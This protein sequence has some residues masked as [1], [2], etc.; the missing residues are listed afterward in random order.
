MGFDPAG[1]GSDEAVIAYRYGGWYGEMIAAKGADTADGSSMAALLMK[2]RRDA[3]P[4][5][6]DMGGGYGGAVSMRLD[7]NQVAF[8]KFNGAVASAARTEDGSLSFVNKRAEAYWRFREELNPDRHG[9]SVIALPPDPEL[10]ADLAAPTWS[11]RPNGILL[12]SK[13]DLRKR[14]GRSPGKGDAVVMA[15]STGEQAVKRM[16]KRGA[17]GQMPEVRI[18]YAAL[19]TRRR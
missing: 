17:M 2:H 5:V 14:L 12:E 15:L 8:I 3:A 13:E 6:I 18:G 19:K 7:D 4:V 1:G 9:G 16:A 11:L 10:R